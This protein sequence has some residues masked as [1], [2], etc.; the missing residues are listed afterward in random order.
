MLACLTRAVW[1]IPAIRPLNATWT[2][3]S[4]T[5]ILD[6]RH[7]VAECT[8]KAGRRLFAPGAETTAEQPARLPGGVT[9]VGCRPR[10]SQAG[11]R[12]VVV[13]DPRAA[14]CFGIAVPAGMPARLDC[15]WNMSSRSWK[16][17]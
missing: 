3:G 7:V 6:Q 14:V 11:L 13:L 1:P 12:R 5:V 15:A 4:T 17:S 8:E 9:A 2:G 16:S 10:F